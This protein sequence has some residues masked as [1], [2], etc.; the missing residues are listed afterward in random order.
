MRPLPRQPWER[1]R[2]H[3]YT[4]PGKG[5]TTAALGL[6]LRA[7]GRGMRVWVG[8]WMKGQPYGELAT[9]EV[10][11]PWITIEQLGSPECLPWSDQPPAQEVA[12]ARRGLARAGEILEAGQHDLVVLDE[13]FVALYFKLLTLDEVLDLLSRRPEG[14]ELVLTGRW[15]PP[16]LLEQADYV[17][18]MEEGAHPYTTEG[19]LARDG[20]ER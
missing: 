10:L 19:L 1:G 3:A 16:E 15:A 9:V 20:I 18:V 5:K 2:V 6:A 13:I 8:Q 12:L 7:A 17:T 14:V 11:S 4:G